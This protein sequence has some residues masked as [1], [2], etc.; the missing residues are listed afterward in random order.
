MRQLSCPSTVEQQ[1]PSGRGPEGCHH[2]ISSAGTVGVLAEWQNVATFSDPEIHYVTSNLKKLFVV[3]RAIASCVGLRRD[4]SAWTERRVGNRVALRVWDESVGF[5]RHAQ[6][7][8]GPRHVE[9]EL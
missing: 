4:F 2:S 5:P 3:P 1:R 7:R 9:T 6:P 8:A